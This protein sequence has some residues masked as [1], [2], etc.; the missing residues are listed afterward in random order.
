M[1]EKRKILVTAA[2]PYA[3]GDIHMGHL[4]EYIQTDIWVRFQK[5]RGHE[6][7]YICADDTH[8]TA[9]MLKA[10]EQNISPDVL[11]ASMQER[12]AR[13]FCDFQVAFDNYYTTNSPENKAFSCEFYEKMKSKGHIETKEIEQLFCE[14]DN[15]FLPDRFIKGICP[16]CKAED[17]YGDCCEKCLATYSTKDVIDPKCTVCGSKPIYKSSEHLFFQLSHFQE[18]LKGWVK[19]HLSPEIQNKLNEWLEGELRD[20]DISRDAPYFGFQIPGTD[21]KYFYVWVDAPIGYIASTKNWCDK[22]NRNYEEFWKNDDA[23]L[24]HFIGKDILYFHTL[25]W[26][27]MLETAEYKKPNGVFVHGFLTINGEKMSKTR[28]TFINARDYLEFLDPTSLRFYYACKMNPQFDDI[29]LNFEDYA[30]RVNSDLVGKITNLASRLA[31]M[32]NKKLDSKLGII[33]EDGAELIKF[34]QD[35]SNEI[36]DHF[37]NRRFSRAMISIREIADEA[38][39]YID[40]KEPWKLIKTDLDETRNII[41]VGLNVFRII[42]IYL[43]PVLPEYSALV[44]E[45]FNEKPFQWSS[46]ENVLINHKI[47]KFKHLSKRVEMKDVESL[48]E[49]SKPS[50]PKE[51][52]EKSKCNYESLESEITIDDFSKID[53]RVGTITEANL[54]KGADKLLQLT[55]DIGFETRNVLAGIKE[56]YDPKDLIGK[57]VS[58]VANLKPRKMKFGVSEGMILAAGP[59]GKDIHILSPLT[60]SKNGDRIN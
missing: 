23:E 8:G 29:D 17:Q 31:P 24:Y 30:N 25:F 37:E 57:Q 28:G 9:I 48:L 59:G 34:A 16:K 45:L 42:S 7:I 46:T 44:S 22:N 6:C 39:K 40:K 52:E 35:K 60:N 54:V 4:V 2:L 33:P 32:L 15:I 36:S 43:S 21:E 58:L 1:V 51:V 3:N 12:H 26:P 5:L 38:N 41:T 50:I 56:A 49:K 19:D 53:L 47:G 20:W 27:A 14:K 11:V 10:Q 18:F 55:V 13:D